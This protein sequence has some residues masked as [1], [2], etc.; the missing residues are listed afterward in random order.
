VPPV[1]HDAVTLRHFAAVDALDVLHAQ[2]GRHPEPR[3]TEAVQDEIAAAERA[4]EA[5]CADIL[6]ASWLGAAAEPEEGNLAAVYRIQVGL[7]EGLRPPDA[8]LGEAQ[9][10]HFAEATGGT[11]ATDDHGAYVFATRRPSLGPGRVIDTVQ[12]LR[13]AVAFGEITSVQAAKIADDIESAGRSLRPEHRQ[14]R[15]AA[16]F[17]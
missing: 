8:H 10:I 17:D 3:W 1:L 6:S 14:S 16:Y 11:V 15:N 9:A 4:G 7:N 13:S 5:H 12:I 2:H